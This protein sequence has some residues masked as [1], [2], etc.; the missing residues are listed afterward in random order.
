MRHNPSSSLIH[1]YIDIK[2]KAVLIY[3][4]L[5]TISEE[6]RVIWPTRLTSTKLLFILNRYVSLVTYSLTVVLLL[7]REQAII[8][9]LNECGIPS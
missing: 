2:L 7:D 5:L 9:S 6:I 3:D 4:H 1:A 8:V